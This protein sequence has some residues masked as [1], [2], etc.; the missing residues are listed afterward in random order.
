M[1]SIFQNVDFLCD[2]TAD[3]NFSVGQICSVFSLQVYA[4]VMVPKG[5]E[6]K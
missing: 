6:R 4:T 1:A 2:S 3:G 5:S